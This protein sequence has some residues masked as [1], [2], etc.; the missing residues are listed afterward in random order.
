M[1][2]QPQIEAAALWLS[3]L[4]PGHKLS[5]ADRKEVLSAFSTIQR[6]QA[7]A[8]LHARGAPFDPFLVVEGTAGRLRQMASGR[9][10]VLAFFVA[11]DICE[12][13]DALDPAADQFII[14]FSACRIA[15]MPRQTL[16]D[17]THFSSRLELA[18][19]RVE[20]EQHHTTEEW[21]VNLGTRTAAARLANL[22]CELFER[23]ERVGLVRAST[24]DLPLTQQD[25]A[26]AAGL[27]V[28]YVNR[29]LQ[30]FRREKLLALS[31]GILQILDLDRLRQVGE[32]STGTFQ[33][34]DQL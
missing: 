25:L 24:Y 3:R 16:F 10:Q 13:D 23:L 17:L 27:S 4:D 12:S 22:F 19:Q 29:V 8:V 15:F 32:F 2:P 6:F 11:G 5:A 21:L 7:R 34:G 18:L 30:I 33:R 1:Q 26:D 31:G 14:G 20:L 28:I 9:R